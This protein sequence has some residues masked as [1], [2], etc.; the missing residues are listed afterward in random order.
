DEGFF[1]S[2]AW[3]R[4]VESQVPAEYVVATAAGRVVAALPLYRVDHEPNAWY[5]PRRLA[6]LV[7]ADEPVVLAGSR[8]GYRSTLLGAGAAGL[9]AALEE[10][11][12]AA[13]P[14][15]F[16]FLTSRAPAALAAAAPVTA[17]PD[18][19]EAE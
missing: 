13:G 16:P 7:G 15:V 9:G 3:L 10:A 14:L 8:A 2:H 5:D 18:T 11:L 6:A 17:A 1:V 12:S 4:F 19:V